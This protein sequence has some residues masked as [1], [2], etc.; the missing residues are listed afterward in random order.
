VNSPDP[1]SSHFIPEDDRFNRDFAAVEKRKR[2]EAIKRR[3]EL[4]DS[5]RVQKYERDLKRWEYME[6]E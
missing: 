6:E 2:E 4:I 3:Q 5:K 1:T